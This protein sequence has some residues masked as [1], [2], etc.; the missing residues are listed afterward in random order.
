MDNVSHRLSHSMHGAAAEDRASEGD[1]PSNLVEALR[2]C[3]LLCN[4]TSPVEAAPTS[5][6]EILFKVRRLVRAIGVDFPDDDADFSGAL[7]R[8]HKAADDAFEAWLAHEH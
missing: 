3:A 8:A 2:E 7:D 5:L 1:W 4:N 6:A